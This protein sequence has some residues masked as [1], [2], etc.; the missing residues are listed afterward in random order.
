LAALAW[1]GA[2]SP[3]RAGPVTFVTALPGAQNELIARFQVSYTN[4]S[5]GSAEGNP[6]LTKFSFPTVL[7]YGPI[8]SLAVFLTVPAGANRL[9]KQTRQ[10]PV[11]R[12]SSGFGDTLLFAR[13]T[14]FHF[15]RLGRTFRLAPLVGFYF[16]TGSYTKSDHLGRLPDTLQTGS[17][18][19]GPYFGS[20]LTWLN[21]D[22]EFDWDLTY[23]YNP[24]ASSGFKLGDELRSDASFEF[25]VLPWLLPDTGVPDFLLGI[26]ETNLIRDAVNRES[27]R[28]ALNSGGVTWYI[29]P[30]FYFSTPPWQAAA[31]VQLPVVEALNGSGRVTQSFRI[32]AFYQHS[33][34]LPPLLE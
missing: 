7:G 17:G 29:D 10:G 8:S 16:P 15:D 20:A 5:G 22:Y 4:G 34:G 13:Y 14:L 23:R 33:F 28:A 3:A 9:S 24:A 31:V 18:S 32:F 27:G 12:S 2:S 26:L 1:L 6:E 11:T 21:F 19:V 30:G 25:R